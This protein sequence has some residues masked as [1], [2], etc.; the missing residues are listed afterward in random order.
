MQFIYEIS[1]LLTF[2]CL[3]DELSTAETHDDWL[4]VVA[5]FSVLVLIVVLITE[6][7]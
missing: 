6:N 7:L 4:W 3:L 1:M 5:H 2:I